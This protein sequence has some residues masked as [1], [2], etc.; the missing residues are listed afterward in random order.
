M[1]RKLLKNKVGR[2]WELSKKDLERILKDT[3]SLV[4]KGETYIKDK[5]K[6]G[7]EM[8][9]A[10]ALALEREKSYYEL[11]KSLVK[12]PKSKW[13]NNKKVGDYLTKIKKISSKIK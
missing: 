11:G 13:A 12:L 2:L 1:E 9:E 3:S 5:S 10:L 6:E 7:R 4:K 8:L